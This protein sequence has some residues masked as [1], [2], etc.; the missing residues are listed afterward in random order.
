MS[1]LLDKISLYL[2][3]FIPIAIITGPF[4]PDLFL[5]TI[6]I[7]F[8]Y[9]LI[10]N[11]EW[12]KLNNKYFFILVF[13]CLFLVI[14]SLLSENVFLSL[15][16]TLFYF[17]FGIFCFATY[18]LMNKYDDMIIKNLTYIILFILFFLLV[19][20]IYD[21]IFQKNIITG[22]TIRDFRHTGFF[23]DDE[24]IGSYTARLFPFF[25]FI[26]LKKNPVNTKLIFSTF[27]ITGLIIF[28]SSERTSFFFYLVTLLVFLMMSENSLRK[29]ILANIFFIISILIIFYSFN[30]NLNHRIKQTYKQLN[31]MNKEL[32]RPN[33]I[34]SEG[35]DAIEEYTNKQR[36]IILFSVAHQSHYE[37]AYKMFKEKPIF[38]HG[39]KMFRHYCA[40]KENYVNEFACTTHPHNVLMQFL[41]ETGIILS[42]IVYFFYLLLL[43][44]LSQSFFLRNFKKGYVINYAQVCFTCSILIT[45]FPFSPS[46]N[47]FDNWLSLVYY[48]P[49]GIYLWHMKN[50]KLLN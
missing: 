39:V 18:Y 29:A 20:Q 23:G 11:A 42:T 27:I 26:F 17:R 13:L 50:L 5:S 40:K 44:K 3:L 30:D 45:F 43:F 12:K 14:N 28:L 1:N 8:L 46:G 21:L 37:I 38:G 15:K 22:Q 24:I 41:S 36:S 6:V 32:T 10:R 31:F 16:P 9:K 34:I 25:L 47:F 2:L 19:G 7:I 35:H 33:L 49:I 4:L 48:Y